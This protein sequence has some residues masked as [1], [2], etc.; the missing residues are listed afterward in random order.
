MTETESI[1]QPLLSARE[2][3]GGRSTSLA[4]HAESVPPTPLILE[5]VVTA[6]AVEIREEDKEN[7]NVCGGTESGNEAAQKKRM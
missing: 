5:R 1:F 2:L 3:Q 6:C 7:R 4:K